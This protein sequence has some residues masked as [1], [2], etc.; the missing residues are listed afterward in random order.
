[1]WTSAATTS[2]ARSRGGR[3]REDLYYR[4]RVI[5]V[6][7]PALRERPDD[8]LPLARWKIVETAQ[9]FGRDVHGLTGAAAKTLLAH[10]WPGNVRELHNTIERAVVF[11][12]G[13]AIDV[14]DLDLSTLS[15]AAPEPTTGPRSVSGT[16]EEV[17]RAHILATL[18]ATGGNR[19]EAARRLGIGSAT[20]FRRL[21][22]WGR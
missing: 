22:R 18:E 8:V 10:P 11:A 14:G 9:R 4:L 21:K 1:M 5:E 7:I 12:E 20:L 3:F 6:R 2:S 13:D 16:L 15:G 19:A 17:E